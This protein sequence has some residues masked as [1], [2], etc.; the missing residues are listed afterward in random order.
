[1]GL[2]KTITLDGDVVVTDAYHVVTKFNPCLPFVPI[3]VEVYASR[4]RYKA[5]GAKLAT[6]HFG[7]SSFDKTDSTRSAHKQVYQWLKSLPEYL[8]ADDVLE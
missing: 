5:G 7:M 2:K 8:G 6:H 3:V 4:D 1:M